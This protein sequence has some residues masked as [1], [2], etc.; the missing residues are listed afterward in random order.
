MVV[1]C[2]LKIPSL[3]I[4]VWHHSASLMI[5][6]PI[7][8]YLCEPTSHP[9]NFLYDI[10]NN[11]GSDKPTHLQS[12]ARAFAVH[13]DTIGNKR[14]L[15]KNSHN[16][17]PFAWLHMGFWRNSNHLTLI[18]VPFALETDHVLSLICLVSL[19]SATSSSSPSSSSSS[20]SSSG[21]KSSSSS[22]S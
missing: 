19:P 20:S 4:N 10:A 12:L 13:T 7:N 8:S 22:S 16:S 2:E 14:K 5:A 21:P 18:E 17:G 1:W 15:Q 3:R 6:M 9:L 11:K